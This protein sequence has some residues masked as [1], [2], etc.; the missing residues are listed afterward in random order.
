MEYYIKEEIAG[1]LSREGMIDALIHGLGTT[2]ALVKSFCV[3][4]VELSR[5]KNTATQGDADWRQEL[6]SDETAQQK[7][8]TEAFNMT[9]IVPTMTVSLDQ[10]D[11]K[12]CP[13]KI[14]DGELPI[15]L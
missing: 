6:L 5:T 10:S 2:V 9:P 15:V 12:C 7:L 3:L 4:L 1:R 14:N 13:Y 8:I 11:E